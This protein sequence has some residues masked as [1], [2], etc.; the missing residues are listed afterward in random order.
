VTNPARAIRA[1]N[2]W[3]RVAQLTGWDEANIDTMFTS[4]RQAS[5]L[6]PMRVEAGLRQDAG[7]LSSLSLTTKCPWWYSPFDMY[8]VGMMS[9]P[10][11]ALFGDTSSGKS[12]FIKTTI[13]RLIEKGG[14]SVI[15]D[16]KIQEGEGY[17][18]HGEYERL[19]MR[20]PS[21]QLVLDRST[22]GTT[23]N[24]FDPA[25]API[26]DE[27][28]HVGQDELLRLA[29]EVALER[30]LTQREG[31]ALA[32]AHGQALRAAQQEQRVPILSDVVQAL[33]T[34]DVDSVPGPV[35]QGV[36]VLQSMDLVTPRT[37]V[38]WGLEVALALGRY[39]TGDLSGLIDGPTH[40]PGGTPLDLSAPLLVCDTTGMTP[41]SAA[42]GLMQMVVIGY[43]ESRWMTI[44][45]DKLIV[46][47]EAYSDADLP[48]VAKMLKR[49]V[50][51][52]RGSGTMMLSAWHHLVDV[53][54]GSDL[55]SL[56]KDTG[57]QHLFR[58]KTLADAEALCAFWGLDPGTYVGTLTSL[59]KGCHLAIVGDRPPEIIQHLRTSDEV[60]IT[61]TDAAVTGLIGA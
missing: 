28:K 7:P 55:E 10:N 42:L 21:A 40:G 45:G 15:F 12:S 60:W 36:K 8:R 39:I 34:M 52:G 43:L 9:S 35:D 38:E 57:V 5:I 46:L 47:E 3:L 31:E 53:P 61:D 20:V 48:R 14:R 33:Y 16:R 49:T 23:I 29:A 50:K 58:Q 51:R 4:T 32:R 19:A 54:P 24:I 56:I 44:P 17:S 6:N 27:E 37:M 18:G 26:D 59:S 30:P 13:E 2:F 1:N 11:G 22:S 25:I 41:G